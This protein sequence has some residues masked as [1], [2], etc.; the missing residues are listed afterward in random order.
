MPAC[1]AAR[2][3]LE[4]SAR[5]VVTKEMKALPAWARGLSGPAILDELCAFDR[6][7]S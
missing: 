7:A 2:M 1:V 3:G 6:L 4:M 5:R